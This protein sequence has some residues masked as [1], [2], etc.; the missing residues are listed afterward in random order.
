MRTAETERHPETLGRPD[1]HI[2]T[3][4]TGRRQQGKSEQVGRH[5]H[6]AVAGVYRLDQIAVIDDLTVRRRV[7]QH[8]RETVLVAPFS[9]VTDHDPHAD[10]FGP[11][12]HDVDGLWMATVR[13]EH[14][15]RP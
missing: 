6:H 12:S 14:D 8:Q 5:D 10:R 2:R 13:H 15:I 11:G 7:L 3:P 4:F 9:L 1:H